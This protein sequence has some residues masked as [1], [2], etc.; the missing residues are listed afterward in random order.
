MEGFQTLAKSARAMQVTLC[1]A[2][3]L[4]MLTARVRDVRSTILCLSFELPMSFYSFDSCSCPGYILL[5]FLPRHVEL[6]QF[7]EIFSQVRHGTREESK[8]VLVKS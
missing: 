1:K 7:A 2:P 8:R 3:S 4:A 6:I 5:P